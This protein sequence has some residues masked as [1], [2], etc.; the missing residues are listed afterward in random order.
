MLIIADGRD[1]KDVPQTSFKKSQDSEDV[2]T[3]SNVRGDSQDVP[4]TSN[5][6]SDVEQG[7]Q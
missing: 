3:S 6:R 1:L 2:Q 4:K 5:L 7:E